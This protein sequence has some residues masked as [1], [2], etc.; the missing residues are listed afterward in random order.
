MGRKRRPRFGS[1]FGA[2]TAAPPMT[3]PGINARSSKATP[4]AMTPMVA[5][6]LTRDSSGCAAGA[7]VVELRAAERGPLTTANV[8]LGT[9]LSLLMARPAWSGGQFDR[10]LM[11]IA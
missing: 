6:V 3:I 10:Q 8:E 11:N 4:A 9:A 2:S 7:P 1:R 5:A